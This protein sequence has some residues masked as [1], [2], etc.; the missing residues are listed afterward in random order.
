WEWIAKGNLGENCYIRGDYEK[1]VPLL[2]Y[3]YQKAELAGDSANAA[4][5]LTI[6]AAIHLKKKDLIKTMKYIQRAHYYI[7]CS[8]QKERLRL[9]YPIISGWYMV[10]GQP[11]QANAYLDSTVVAINLYNET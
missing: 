9:L 8:G 4:G 6:L 3:N 2:E 10:N 1:A 11:G 7:L 5:S